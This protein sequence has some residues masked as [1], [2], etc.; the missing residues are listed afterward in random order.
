MPQTRLFEDLWPD[1]KTLKIEY[2]FTKCGIYFI[3]YVRANGSGESTCIKKKKD[4]REK[5]EKKEEE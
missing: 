4:D 2:C 3:I 5:C 1:Q